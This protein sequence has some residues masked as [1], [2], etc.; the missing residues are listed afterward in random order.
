MKYLL[1]LILAFGITSF[2]LAQDKD[3][4]MVYL[5]PEKH[6]EFK[7]G[8]AGWTK[9]LSSNLKYP[10]LATKMGAEGPVWVTFV[11]D[12]KGKV[13]DPT[14][15]KSP[16]ESLSKEA[17]RVLKRSPKWKPAKHEG[18]TVRSRVQVQI[19]FKLPKG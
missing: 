15:L 16:H 11:I 4:E 13:I 7:G 3:E 5:Q 18:K 1:T 2:S 12:K 17:V 6:A 10:T 14:V 9:F 19:Q 8:P